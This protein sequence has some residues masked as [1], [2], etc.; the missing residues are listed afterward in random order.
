M[1]IKDEIII[2]RKGDQS[3]DGDFLPGTDGRWNLGSL[4]KRWR[5]I[6]AK[7]LYSENIEYTGY[8]NPIR[9][10]TMSSGLVLIEAS[11]LSL[12]SDASLTDNTET[13]ILSQASVYCPP[14]SLVVVHGQFDTSVVSWSASASVYLKAY[15]GSNAAGIFPQYV[16]NVGRRG[17]TLMNTYQYGSTGG[18]PTIKITGQLSDYTKVTVKFWSSWTKLMYFVY[19]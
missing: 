15:I 18:T 3:L 1:P 19:A 12:G 7:T 16:T 10:S 6:I 13:D 5:R 11:E 8:L 14:N 17:W 2:P 4:T 9:G